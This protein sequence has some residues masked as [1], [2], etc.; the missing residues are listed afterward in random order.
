MT[1]HSPS[2]NET[3]DAKQRHWLYGL[4]VTLLVIIGLVIIGLLLYMTN[5]FRRPFDLTSGG[6]YSLS[7]STKKLIGE[8]DQK[9]QKYELVTL[10]NGRPSPGETPTQAME[11]SRRVR[12][13]LDEYARRSKSITV[14]NMSDVPLDELQLKIAQRYQP[15]IKPYA[16]AVKEFEK[17]GKDITTFMKSEAGNFS[18]MAQ[19]QG[20]DPKTAAVANQ[21]YAMMQT[22]IPEAIQ[23]TQKALNRI[24]DAQ[25]PDYS[26]AVTAIKQG[27]SDPTGQVD[28]VSMLTALTDP[29]KPKEFG[30]EKYFTD[31]Q[32]RY[33]ALLD[34][35]KSYSD[36][37]DKLQPLKLTEVMGSVGNDSI[38]VLGPETVKVISRY[39][40][41]KDN[42]TEDP[43]PGV[44]TSSF[45]GEQAI[46]SAL[47]SMVQPDKLKVVFVTPTPNQITTRGSDDSWTA[48]A[49]RLKELNFDVLEW[50]PPGPQMSPD[51]PPPQATPPATGKG[52][53]WIVFPPDAP[54]AQQMMSGMPPPDPKPIIE[55][56]KTHLA[57]GGRALLLASSGGGSPFGGGESYAF[58]EIAKSFGIVVQ[59]K[60]TVVRHYDL[61]D[62]EM[63]YPRIV[64]TRYPDTEI[65]RPM[66]SLQTIFMGVPSRGGMGG[67]MGGPTI[68]GL[69]TTL[70]QGVEAKVLVN[71]PN[72]ADHWG[73]TAYARDAKFDKGTD[74][75]PPCPMAASSVKNRGDKDKEQRLVVI[76]STFIGIDAQTRDMGLAQ[77]GN[78][79][80]RYLTNP[81]N[82]ELVA[83]SV[84][85]LGGYENMIAVSSKTSAAQRIQ[86]ISPGA[87]TA[88]RTMV[89]FLV[90]FGALVLG[91]VVWLFR[92]R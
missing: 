57:G 51:Q 27:L 1:Q 79:I 32:P 14:E 73:E 40:I 33:K 68:V 30:M 25:V 39:D 24:T 86:D 13:L 18:A 64:L 21:F 34:E 63:A 84:L 52:V 22:D 8:L 45:E 77:Q 38:V 47:L 61:N 81:G 15:E 37:L 3:P 35:V 50:S 92:R 44:D 59:P 20:V 88:V 90:P 80:V 74:Y 19:Q 69:D 48:V 6:I 56:L 54:T 76:G 11:N 43:T 66:Q 42:P 70:P 41:I 62:Q 82:T 29:A 17:V 91:G 36:R 87:L 55:A 49:D 31:A 75:A 58:D 53:V 46:S 2:A 60:Y 89:F 16:E 78:R 28:L 5:T 9:K 67:I 72:D 10:F 65:T 26:K 4:N 85:W 7:D 12:D 23:D 71:T 83:N